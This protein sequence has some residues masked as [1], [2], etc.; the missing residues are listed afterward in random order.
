MCCSIF[1]VE[2]NHVEPH[3]HSLLNNH[4]NVNRTIYCRVCE[5]TDKLDTNI[6]N[7]ITGKHLVVKCAVVSL[8]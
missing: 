7:H 8:I 1:N 4:K 3:T 6:E 2:K 5:K